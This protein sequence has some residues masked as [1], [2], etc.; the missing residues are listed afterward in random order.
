MGMEVQVD[1]H[2]GSPGAEN[3]PVG[4]CG[5]LF[6]QDKLKGPIRRAGLGQQQ[7]QGRAAIAGA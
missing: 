3:N 2:D 1:I 4:Y 6:T 5:R 7:Q